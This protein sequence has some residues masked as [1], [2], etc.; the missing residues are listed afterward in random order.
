MFVSYIEV[1]LAVQINVHAQPHLALKGPYSS[2]WGFP[3][4]V[5]IGFCEIK[6]FA[7]ANIPVFPPWGVSL[8]HTVPPP[9]SRPVPSPPPCLKRLLWTPLFTT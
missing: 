3:S 6:W 7:K 8:L 1:H 4:S 9:P 2:L 5:N